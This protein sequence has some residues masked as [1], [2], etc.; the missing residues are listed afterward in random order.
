MYSSCCTLYIIHSYPFIQK[1]RE[2]NLIVPYN[3]SNNRT[4]HLTRNLENSILSFSFSNLTN[5]ILWHRSCLFMQFFPIW[6]TRYVLPYWTIY[7]YN[8]YLS[9][10][11]RTINPSFEGIYKGY[12]NIHIHTHKIR[13]IY[14]IPK[15]AIFL[16]I[17]I[18][19]FAI[20]HFF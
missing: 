19:I 18:Y 11:L 17:G 4:A 10:V 8:F 15:R 14:F 2:K 3:D 9:M 12:Q 7:I 1:L 13:I 20:I 5:P 6:A 16:Y